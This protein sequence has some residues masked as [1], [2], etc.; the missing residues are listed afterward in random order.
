MVAETD[1]DPFFTCTFFSL[2]LSI[3]LL[4]P[5]SSSLSFFS[6]SL[7]LSLTLSLKFLFF[8]SL[9]RSS[10]FLSSLRLFTQSIFF[11]PLPARSL[12]PP[13]SV[14]VADKSISLMLLDG[15]RKHNRGLLATVAVYFSR[16]FSSASSASLFSILL[17]CRLN[18]FSVYLSPSIQPSVLFSTLPY[19]PVA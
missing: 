17:P 18:S 5:L 9:Y 2:P 16:Y 13:L 12:S 3:P 8:S 10:L 19:S 15:G 14:S 7:F 11:L 6:L 4:L 1:D